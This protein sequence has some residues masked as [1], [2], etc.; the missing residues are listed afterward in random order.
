MGEISSEKRGCGFI[1]AI[2]GRK[3]RRPRRSTSTGS[4]PQ[5]IFNNNVTRFPSTPGSRT[6]K[7][8]FADPPNAKK[9]QKQQADRIIER[10][11]GSYPRAPHVYK[12][13][14]HQ[15][16]NKNIERARAGN[17]QGYVQARKVPPTGPGISGE[18]ESMIMDYQKSKGAASL[19]RASSS[20][21]M[22]FGNLGNLRQSGGNNNSTN[23]AS[24]NGKYSTSVMGNVVKKNEHEPEKPVVSL[25]RA[26]STRMDPEELKI[27]GNEDYKNGRYA[28]ALALYDAAISVDPNKASYRSNKSAAL[29]ALG[30]LLEAAFECREAIRIEPSYQRAHN[31]LATLYVRLGEPEKAVYHFK[32]S[33][34]E[35]DPDAMNNAKT[36]QIHLNKCT[37]AKKR[38]DWNGVLTETSLSIA[39]GADSAPLVFGLKAEALLK[40]NRREE[41]IQTMQNGPNFD[42]DDCTK[43]FGPIGSASLLVYRAQVNL[44]AGRFEDSVAA[45]Q[46]ATRLDPNNKE[47]M[48]VLRRTKGV[49]TARANGN[50]LFKIARYSE[51]SI[52]YGEGLSYDPYNAVLLCNRAACKSKLGQYQKALDDCNAAL[53]VRPTYSK[54]RLRRADCYAKMEKWGACVQDCKVLLRENPDDE[55]V[56][57]MVKEAKE[58]LQKHG[59]NLDTNVRNNH[60]TGMVVVSSNER[61]RDYATSP[62]TSVVLFCKK[63]GDRKIMQK[64][65]QLNQRY[66]SLNFLK[67]E[68]DDHPSLAKSEGVNSFPTFI[69]YTNGSR[70]KEIPGDNYVLLEKSIKYYVNS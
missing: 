4:L 34:P 1:S 56:K 51:A 2:F 36:V 3:G 13:Q 60:G 29:V 47:A 14:Q 43:F 33:G 30:K 19:I 40:L 6:R 54:A 38:G 68:V 46:R 7:D 23:A 15:G 70:A 18:L 67:V 52:A 35:A 53:N 12:P 5:T 16:P 27:L 25:C 59:G 45:A 9:D 69:I 50:E 58:N 61:F 31:R 8:A 39:A 17:Q 41:A 28:E 63:V 22:L 26:L 55:E 21:V 10:P 42:I 66:P 49:A 57:K 20:N 11:A 62:G 64:I 32:Q 65:E 24:V 48:V 37:D 44:V